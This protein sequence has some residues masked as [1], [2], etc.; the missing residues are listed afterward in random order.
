LPSV[1]F[2]ILLALALDGVSGRVRYGLAAV[3]LLFHFAALQHNL[4]FWEAA[5]E[6]VK[7]ECAMGAPVLPDS[8]NG[9]PALANGRPECIEIAHN[10]HRKP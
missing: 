1:W 2:A 7:A 3:V 8:I 5:S 9:V 6:R 10:R 4:G